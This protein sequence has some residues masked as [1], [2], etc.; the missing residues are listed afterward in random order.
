[1]GP[2]GHSSVLGLVEGLVPLAAPM[3]R[4]DARDDERQSLKRAAMQHHQCTGTVKRLVCP[5]T[6]R[7][8]PQACRGPSTDIIH[9]IVLVRTAYTV[10]V[11]RLDLSAAYGKDTSNAML[12]YTCKSYLMLRIS[13]TSVCVSS[14]LPSTQEAA[15]RPTHQNTTA[16]SRQ[17]V[18]TTAPSIS[19]EASPSHERDAKRADGM[20]SRILP[21]LAPSTSFRGSTG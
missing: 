20:S 21:R 11:G 7:R 14:F 2:W 9:C 8:N 3:N 16:P 17:T 6:C 4:R 5:T 13:R 18:K 12:R 19:Q 1:M 15:R 10:S